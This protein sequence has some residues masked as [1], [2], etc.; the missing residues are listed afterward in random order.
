MIFTDTPEFCH[1]Q[2]LQLLIWREI[3][4]YVFLEVFVMIKLDTFAKRLGF[5]SKEDLLEDI[6]I[7][8]IP[9]AFC[10]AAEGVMYCCRS[11]IK[12]TAVYLTLSYA[13]VIAAGYVGYDIK[14]KIAD[15]KVDA[16]FWKDL[17]LNHGVIDTEEN[18]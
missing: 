9:A 6:V 10:L 11:K 16:R 2:H 7:E 13:T 12:S 15:W 17:Y 4:N 5:D 8:C 18:N 1:K 3:S 14:Y